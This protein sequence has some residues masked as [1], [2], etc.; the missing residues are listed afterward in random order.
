MRSKTNCFWR[1][2]TICKANDQI[3]SHHFGSESLLTP[4][5]THHMSRPNPAAY[6][7]IL[8]GGVCQWIQSR[9]THQATHIVNDHLERFAATQMLDPSGKAIVFITACYPVSDNKT[10]G[11][12][13]VMSLKKSTRHT[14][15]STG[16]DPV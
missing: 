7:N 12:L 13:T 15:R 4:R 3:F 14:F 1:N 5:N 9:W 11:M 6:S 8:Y 10:E 2:C 16:C